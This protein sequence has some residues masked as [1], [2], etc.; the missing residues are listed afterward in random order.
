MHSIDLYNNKIYSEL[1][2]KLKV[3]YF[4][5]CPRQSAVNHLAYIAVPKQICKSM[6]SSILN[7]D[8]MNCVCCSVRE[9]ELGGGGV[10]TIP[11]SIFHSQRELNGHFKSLL[12]TR[13][14]GHN[15][16]SCH[17]WIRQQSDK[18]LWGI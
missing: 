14:H 7:W 5:S 9:G 17:L 15:T 8:C 13:V 18:L 4:L 10:I 12:I 6:D 1:L 3:L 2:R 16:Q 11:G